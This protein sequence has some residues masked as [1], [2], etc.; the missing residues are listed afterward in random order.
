MNDRDN[1]ELLG[2]DIRI[3]DAEELTTDGGKGAYI[4]YLT[5]FNRTSHSRYINLSL[6]TYVT[7]YR[8]QLEQDAWLN[9]FLTGQE[10][11][12]LEANAY[13][14]A[15]LVFYK[16]KLKSVEDTDTIFIS[17]VLTKEAHELTICY[18]RSGP[19]W[20]LTDKKI[21][22]I[23]I[24][25]TSKEL[26]K[27][28]LK[29]VERL[30]AFEDKLGVHFENISIEVPLGY[31]EWAKLH[32]ELHSNTGTTISDPLSVLCVAYDTEGLIIDSQYYYVDSGKFFG[33]E[34]FSFYFQKD[35]IASEIGKLRIF[36]KIY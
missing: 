30:E 18:Q 1:E 28:L 35:G 20:V 21:S 12:H 6:A 10:E 11:D 29:K 15:G 31:K 9:G 32:G 3:S 4:F 16:S 36:P 7:H 27:M 14:R 23:Q 8:E 26:E 22:D 17:L 19:K 13:K 34:V 2:L 24:T 33:F 5:V 25:L